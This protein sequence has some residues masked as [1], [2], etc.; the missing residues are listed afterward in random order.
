MRP[1]QAELKE[2][3][4]SPEWVKRLPLGLDTTNRGRFFLLVYVLLLGNWYK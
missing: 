2:L 4:A 3:A 1:S